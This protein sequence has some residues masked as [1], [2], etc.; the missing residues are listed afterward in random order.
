V[1]AGDREGDREE[2]PALG[3]E[4]EAAGAI[5]HVARID[6]ALGQEGQE[7]ASL[8][9]REQALLAAAQQRERH[10]PG[11]PLDHDPVV[12]VEARVEAERHKPSPGLRASARD[13][14]CDHRGGR[15]G[16]LVELGGDDLPAGQHL[17]L[18]GPVGRL[19]AGAPAAPLQ[20][21]RIGDRFGQRGQDLVDAAAG[22][23][24]LREL[25]L[26]LGAVGEHREFM[27]GDL[28]VDLL[29]DLD[30]R[31]LPV[32]G[33]ERQHPRLGLVD[34]GRGK[35]G[36][37]LPE[38]D[39]QPGDVAAGQFADE[40]ALRAGAGAEPHPGHQQQLA[41][42]Q[43]RRD[44]GHLARVNPANAPPQAAPA[45]QHLGR[46]APQRR[47]AERLLDRERPL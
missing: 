43:Q 10:Q 19:V 14:A 28:S 32:Q 15:F 24:Q 20:D 26:Q 11:G 17:G 40:P 27:A 37:H 5:L 22:Q 45:G 13:L 31:H 23:H 1:L 8:P 33:D 46:A 16:P 2:R 3:R 38:L 41:A 7:V 21:H 4:S 42:A 39:D 6:P 34:H 25:V 44:V 47:Q 18:R 36:K 29:G 35:L 30:E 9:G 12:V